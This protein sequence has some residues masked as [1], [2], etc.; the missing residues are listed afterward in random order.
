MKADGIGAV[1]RDHIDLQESFLS[2]SS[3]DRRFKRVSSPLTFEEWLARKK[4]Q[5]WLL[6]R[7]QG[8]A[9]HSKKTCV[10]CGATFEC[11][12]CPQRY[13]LCWKSLDWRNKECYCLKCQLDGKLVYADG[14]IEVIECQNSQK[15]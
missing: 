6:N 7:P 2:L 9:I 1:K 8:W 11:Y 10:V 13:Y 14:H 3:S 5:F 4:E 15:S 12:K